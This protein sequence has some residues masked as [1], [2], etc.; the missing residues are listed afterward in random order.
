M[1]SMCLKW[2]A[3]QIK[4]AGCRLMCERVAPLRM[5]QTRDDATSKR[6][7]ERDGSY[8]GAS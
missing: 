3:M 6:I 2:F 4:L 1:I 8:L 5:R 7:R